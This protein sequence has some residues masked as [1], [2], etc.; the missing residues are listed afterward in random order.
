MDQL[1]ERSIGQVQMLLLLD[2]RSR[3]CHTLNERQFFGLLVLAT[4]DHIVQGVRDQ[5]VSFLTS[6]DRRMDEPDEMQR[7]LNDALVLTE[8]HHHAASHRFDALPTVDVEQVERRKD[9]SVLTDDEFFAR[10]QRCV[11]DRR[12]DHAIGV[13]DELVKI[14]MKIDL[15]VFA[16]RQLAE[17][18]PD[19]EMLVI[20]RDTRRKE[21]TPGTSTRVAYLCLHSWTYLAV[22]IAFF[23]V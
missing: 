10:R 20:V 4:L 15:F 16:V 3:Y 2:E 6:V 14:R 22:P 21:A 8:V 18:T 7:L 17:K 1:F 19:E 11:V 23:V 5:L 13:G 12:F 9:R